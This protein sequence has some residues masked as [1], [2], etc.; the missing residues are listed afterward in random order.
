M[1]IEGVKAPVLGCDPQ[2]LRA[3]HSALFTQSGQLERIE[4][5]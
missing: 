1:G 5:H 2:S 3:F 4:E